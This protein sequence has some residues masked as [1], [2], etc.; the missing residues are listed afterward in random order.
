MRR[1][2]Q[3]RHHSLVLDA[4]PGL[5]HL[6]PHPLALA[7]LSNSDDGQG[8]GGGGQPNP[9]HVPSPADIAARGQQTVPPAPVLPGQPHQPVGDDQV[10]RDHRTGEPMTQAAFAKIMA[11]ENAKGRRAALRELAENAGVT[12]SGT[13]S[14]DPDDADLERLAKV[15]KDAETTRQAQLTEDQRR[16]EE[17]ANREQ[18]LAAREQEIKDRESAAA[19]RDRDS[20]I[21]AALVRLGATGDDLEDA[22]RLLSVADDA[23]DTAIATAA[24]TLKSRR[25]ELFGTGPAPQTLPPAPSGGPAGGN[26]PRQ[27][28]SSKDAVK[29]AAR[30]RAERMGLRPTG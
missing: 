26:Q 3:P 27:P 28:S 23:D 8:G 4:A 29:E 22:T 19:A 11:R 7:V 9:A 1:P 30:K 10:L 6:Y 18:A 17:L 13:V 21:R 5:K 14:D 24:E 12:V 20:R 25:T 15:L 2:A 16:T